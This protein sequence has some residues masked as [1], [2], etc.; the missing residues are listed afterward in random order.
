MKGTT[1]LT[2]GMMIGTAAAFYYPFTIT[3]ATAYIV[4]ASLSA[5]SADLDGASLLNAKLGPLSKFIH[6]LLN[7]VGWF[8]LAWLAYLYWQKDFFN[9]T[10]I[11]Y[12]VSIILIG[13]ISSHG[14]IRNLLV[15]IIGAII[16]YAGITMHLPWLIGFGAFVVIAPWFKHRGFTH[17]IWAVIAWTWIGYGLELYL[18]IPGIMRI[19]ML[20]YLSH[21]LADTLTPNGVKWLYPLY[22]KAFKL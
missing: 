14:L 11:L 4:V 12:A 1:H 6:R 13:L 16:V 10:Y 18:D 17:T 21:L 20:G 9:T 7:I 19:A 5:L 22:K 8:Y 2:I 3:N 15:S